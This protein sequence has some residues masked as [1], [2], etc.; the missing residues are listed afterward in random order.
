MYGV[1]VK[2]VTGSHNET[3]PNTDPGCYKLYYCPWENCGTGALLSY[4]NIGMWRARLWLGKANTDWSRIN[5]VWP[6]WSPSVVKQL[7]Q[8]WAESWGHHLTGFQQGVWHSLPQHLWWQGLT[9]ADMDWTHGPQDVRKTVWTGW[10]WSMA[11][12]QTLPLT[13]RDPQG[14]YSDQWYSISL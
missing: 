14:E 12:S 6:A 9:H 5:G 2:T 10:W 11:H 4:Y 7:A 1:K 8:W 3:Q 13:S